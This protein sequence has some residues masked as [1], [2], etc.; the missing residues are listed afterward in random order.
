MYDAVAVVAVVNAEAF[1]IKPWADDKIDWTHNQDNSYPSQPF[2]PGISQCSR[3]PQPSRHACVL[4]SADQQKQWPRARRVSATYWVFGILAGTEL[5]R[6][7]VVLLSDW[8]PFDCPTNCLFNCQTEW[9]IRAWCFC[10]PSLMSGSFNCVFVF[11][12][13]QG[14]FVWAAWLAFPRRLQIAG[15]W[16]SFCFLTLPSAGIAGRVALWHA[17]WIWGL[18]VHVWTPS[19]EFS[20]KLT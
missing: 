4:P 13:F 8:L 11:L 10:L 17:L 1:S 16:R 2:V 20:H 6:S 3:C 5:S 9:K 12:P 7:F 14:S 19:W 15:C 18:R